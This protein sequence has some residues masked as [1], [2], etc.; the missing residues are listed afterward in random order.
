MVVV[1]VLRML[2]SAE[3]SMSEPTAAEPVSPSF[4][5]GG[6]PGSLSDVGQR[7]VD[8]PQQFHVVDRHELVA[9]VQHDQRGLAVV[10][11][12]AEQLVADHRRVE[13]PHGRDRL[14]RVVAGRKGGLEA[15]GHLEVGLAELAVLP[16]DDQRDLALGEEV[17]EA[18]L[19]QLL[20]ADARHPVGQIGEVAVVGDVVPPRRHLMNARDEHHPKQQNEYPPARDQRAKSIEY[21][22]AHTCWGVSSPR[23]PRSSSPASNRAGSSPP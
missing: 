20:A 1:S 22:R 5:P 17:G 10:G 19:Q 7:L 15:M 21:H 2:S 4:R 11:H 18:G 3:K 16:R 12:R 9:Q 6:K 23:L 8:P 14:V 13:A